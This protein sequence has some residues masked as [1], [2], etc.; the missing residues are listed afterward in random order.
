MTQSQPLKDNEQ[1][2][3]TGCHEHTR[4]HSQYI[5]QKLLTPQYVKVKIEKKILVKS[6]P[7]SF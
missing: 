7:R 6:S 2:L 4:V 1:K 5:S 3:A